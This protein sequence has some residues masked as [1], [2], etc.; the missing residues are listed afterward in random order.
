MLICIILIIAVS[1]FIV[2][3]FALTSLWRELNA[4][5]LVNGRETGHKEKGLFLMHQRQGRG[6]GRGYAREGAWSGVRGRGQGAHP[7]A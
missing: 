2:K 4:S 7:A 1:R 6:R 3:V 5:V